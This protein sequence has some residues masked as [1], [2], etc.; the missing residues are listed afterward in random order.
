M[1][2][3]A[4][5]PVDG[6]TYGLI[7]PALGFLMAMLGSALGLRCT[8]RGLTAV[9]RRRAGWL[10][11]G[12]VAIGTGIFTMHFIGMMGFT[13]P[14]LP[15]GYDTTIS[16]AS[17]AL[18]IL[19]VGLGLFLVG[20]RHTSVPALLTGGVVTGLGVAGMHYLGMAGMRMEGSLAYDPVIVAL[21]VV[22]A[23]VAATA[24]LW[25]A[26]AARSLGAALGAGVIMAVA[27]NGMHYLGMGALTLHAHTEAV[28]LGGRAPLETLMP[29][30]IGPIVL[31]ILV[32]FVVG[33]DPMT[34]DELNTRSR[35]VGTPGRPVGRVA[36]P[37][38]G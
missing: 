24:A 25:F 22:V 21:S 12:A 18:A 11:L 26:V 34:A 6:F 28:G 31:L 15:I 3:A 19:V 8:V 13:S 32:G 35:G 4:G 29:I 14:A 27:V 16:Y 23:V 37:Q 30:L 33:L 1:H 7:T 38:R 17:L 10:A 9:G 20:R 2:T 36:A 5:V